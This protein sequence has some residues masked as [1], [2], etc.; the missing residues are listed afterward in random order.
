[1]VAIVAGAAVAVVVSILLGLAAGPL[2][3]WSVF[4]G[5]LVV[6]SVALTWSMDAAQTIAHVSEEDRA[7]G[8]PP[9]LRDRQSHESRGGRRRADPDPQRPTP[10]ALAWRYRG[11][12][13]AGSWALIQIDYALRYARVYYRDPVGGIDFNQTEPPMYTDFLYF[14]LGLGMT[15]QVSDTN[16]GSNEVRRMVIGQT[17]C[18]ICS[19]PS[20][21]RPS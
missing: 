9:R 16:V 13:R 6:W 2:A 21:S 3:G 4:T 20:S 5:V 8:C 11:A 14:S 18:P 10:V 7:P 19:V 17:C 12:R 15:Y 1:M